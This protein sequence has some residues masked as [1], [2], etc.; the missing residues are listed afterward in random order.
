[1]RVRIID[2]I[3]KNKTGKVIAIFYDAGEDIYMIQFDNSNNSGQFLKSQ[4]EIL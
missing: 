4:F 1:M 3:H 2:G